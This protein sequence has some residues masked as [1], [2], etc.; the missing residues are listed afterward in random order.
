[1]ANSVSLEPFLEIVA[2]K[3]RSLCYLVETALRGK[4][5]R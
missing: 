2:V 3:M 5:D 4:P 1:M